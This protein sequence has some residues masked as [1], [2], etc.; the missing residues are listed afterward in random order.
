MPKRKI[1]LL[2]SPSSPWQD[3]LGE[4]FD[5]TLSELAVAD[6]SSSAGRFLDR[7]TPD[8]IFVRPP[9]ASP[10]FVQKIKTL[11]MRN[12]DVRL[13]SLE[14]SPGI[15]L[16][17]DFAFSSLPPL[18][19]FLKQ[20]MN[21]LPLPDPIH[22]LIA[23]DEAE[24]GSMIGDYLKE[25]RQPAFE[26]RYAANGRQALELIHDCSPDILLLDIKMPEMD[27]REVYRQLMKEQK[28][29]PVVIFFDAVSTYELEEI[30]QQGSPAVIEKGSSQSAP[31]Q[32]MSFLKKMV[33]FA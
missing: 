31:P 2:D 28:I 30:Y 32:L 9:L 18:S 6:H 19:E 27:G 20:L 21:Q 4:F 11:K 23:D 3:F 1:L 15:D 16:E 7:E 8:L 12:Q 22:L 33:Y 17:P 25:R 14:P 24:I 5:D 13:F 26:V 10:A 29:F